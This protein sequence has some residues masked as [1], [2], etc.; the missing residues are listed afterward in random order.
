MGLVRA[1]VR[2]RLDAR[3]TGNGT[4]FPRAQSWGSW[5]RGITSRLQGDGMGCAKLHPASGNPGAPRNRLPGKIACGVADLAS[6]E[7]LTV[8]VLRYADAVLNPA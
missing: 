8:A 3:P 1:G 4:P 2:V 7:P 6:H 5:Q